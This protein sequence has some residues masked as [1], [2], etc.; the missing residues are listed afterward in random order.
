M[1]LQC[2][3]FQ[4]ETA[5]K[6]EQRCLQEVTQ[7]KI[8]YANATVIDGVCIDITIE[9]KPNEPISKLLFTRTIEK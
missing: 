1:G 8:E 9:R 4:S 6:D 2:G 5:T 3:F 7:K